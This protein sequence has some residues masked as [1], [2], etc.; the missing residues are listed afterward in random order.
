MTLLNFTFAYNFMGV[1]VPT[2]LK[3]EISYRFIRNPAKRL[4]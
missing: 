2:R 3:M 1:S 4:Y